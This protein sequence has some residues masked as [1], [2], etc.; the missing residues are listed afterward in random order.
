MSPFG[1]TPKL[2]PKEVRDILTRFLDGTGSPYEFDDFVSVRI[3]DRQLDEIRDRCAGLWSEFP[4]ER[5]GHYC[6]EAG[7]AVIREFIEELEHDR[8]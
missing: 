6:G 3:G 7:V 8:G 1:P 2:T 4:P 5:P